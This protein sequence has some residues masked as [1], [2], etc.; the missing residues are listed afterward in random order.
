VSRPRILDLYCGAGLVADGLIAAGWDVVGV[1]LNP[2]PRY[3]GPFIQADALSLDQRFVRSFDAVWASPP[4]QFGTSLRNAPGGRTHPNLIPATRKLLL[5]ADLP[6][7]IENVESPAVRAA[8]VEP[9][10]LCGSM[11]GLGAEV[12]G[13]RYQ[14]RRHRLFEANWMIST[15]R[16]THENPV[17]GVYGGHARVRAAS[18]GGRGTLD[19]PGVDDKTA[20]M[21]AAMGVDR[22]VTGNECSQ[23]IPPAFS[24]WVGRQLIRR[25]AEWQR[26]AA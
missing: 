13:V 23:G 5:E 7:V 14:L 18:A 6:F 19:F 11:F 8:L 24:E 1:D 10:R 16:C 22:Y 21:R 12:D 3:P 4:C 25:A 9:V 15:P 20:L 2:Q 26:A 17:I